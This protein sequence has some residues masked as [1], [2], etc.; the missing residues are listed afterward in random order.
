MAL[1]VPS[2]SS[3]VGSVS[4]YMPDRSLRAEQEPRSASGYPQHAV[5]R[6]VHVGGLLLSAVMLCFMHVLAQGQRL[7]Q[8]PVLAVAVVASASSASSSL[9]AATGNHGPA[10]AWR[11]P[12]PGPGGGYGPGAAIHG[13]RLLGIA[14]IAGLRCSSPEDRGLI[15]NT[16]SK[17]GHWWQPTR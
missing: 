15:R 10:G 6:N 12:S 11:P 4:S 5:D 14:G 9:G 13:R 16:S 2:P 3:W 1:L 7:I 8:L 17:E